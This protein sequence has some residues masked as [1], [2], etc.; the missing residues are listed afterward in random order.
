[1][2]PAE[3]VVNL[4]KQAEAYESQAND[5]DKDKPEHRSAFAWWDGLRQLMTDAADYIER[6]EAEKDR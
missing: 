3:I 6:A 4:R 2:K 5:F 1:M